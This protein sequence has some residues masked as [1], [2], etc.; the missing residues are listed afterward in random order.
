MIG[1]PLMQRIRSFSFRPAWS[2]GDIGSTS[3]IKCS[4]QLGR[5]VLIVRP[6]PLYELERW[7][8][9]RRA[10]ERESEGR[11]TTKMFY[12][13]SGE[14]DRRV[15]EI[16]SMSDRWCCPLCSPRIVHWSPDRPARRDYEEQPVTN[17][18]RL[19]PDLCIPMDR[20]ESSVACL[21]NGVE[22]E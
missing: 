21:K 5:S 10:A 7:T 15:N 4:R 1:V 14:R 2:L 11:W 16:C 22:G 19:W 8:M 17:G 6:K 3:R 20:D 9:Q 18:S 12:R 13:C